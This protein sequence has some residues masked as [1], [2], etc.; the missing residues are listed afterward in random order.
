MLESAVHPILRG[1]LSGFLRMKR[2][3]DLTLRSE[4]R[5]R[6]EGSDRARK[7]F[8]TERTTYV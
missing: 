4:H 2:Q 3:A 8:Y 5:E 6:L 1:S 7:R